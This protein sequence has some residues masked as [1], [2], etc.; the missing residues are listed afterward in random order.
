MFILFNNWYG[1]CFHFTVGKYL[2]AGG[3]E[4]HNHTSDSTEIVEF[5][6]TNSTPSFGKLP[7]ARQLAV[8]V[9]F[10]NN[11]MVC[12]GSDAP[13]GTGNSFDACVSFQNSQWIQSHTMN[14]KRFRAAGVQINSTTFWIL[15]GTGSG[16]LDTTE[17]IIQGKYVLNGPRIA[18]N[19]S[20]IVLFTSSCLRSEWPVSLWH[21]LM[22]PFH[23]NYVQCFDL[24]YKG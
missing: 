9:M 22:I 16:D 1:F 24:L 11:P 7:F 4:D 10:G 8:G 2:I 14:E 19:G 15:G 5:L 18:T 3:Y 21:S 6:K 13:G 12:G 23:R 20:V 17:F